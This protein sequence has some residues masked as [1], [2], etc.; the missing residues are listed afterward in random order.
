MKTGIDSRSSEK[1]MKSWEKWNIK[2]ES[3]SDTNTKEDIWKK[4]WKMKNDQR[5]G[6]NQHNIVNNHCVQY[7]PINISFGHLY[8]FFQNLSTPDHVV[9]IVLIFTKLGSKIK[10]CGWWCCC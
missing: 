4:C 10:W 8:H 2:K 1:K 7:K 9:L 5:F 3:K 6:D